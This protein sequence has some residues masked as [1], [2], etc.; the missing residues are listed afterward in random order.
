MEL[1]GTFTRFLIG[2][3]PCSSNRSVM[4]SIHYV[5]MFQWPPPVEQYD[6]NII[7]FYSW[8]PTI[9]SNTGLVQKHKCEVVTWNM[10]E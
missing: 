6:I 9:C 5:P 10:S 7:L 4:I 8:V 2:T 1:H 3:V